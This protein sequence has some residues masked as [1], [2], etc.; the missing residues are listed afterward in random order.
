MT[1]IGRFIADCEV[2][3]GEPLTSATIDVLPPTT[4]SDKIAD[5]MVTATYGSFPLP[6]APLLVLAVIFL[7]SLAVFLWITKTLRDDQ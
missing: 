4:V 7:S 3:A 6:L 1:R 5:R 2:R